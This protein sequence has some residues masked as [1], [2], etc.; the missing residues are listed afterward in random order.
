M[1]NG[2]AMVAAPSSPPGRKSGW[3]CSKLSWPTD[4]RGSPS[5]TSNED[6]T[7]RR[8]LRFSETGKGAFTRLKSTSETRGCI[9]PLQNGCSAVGPARMLRRTATGCSKEDKRLTE[10]STGY[11][12]LRKAFSTNGIESAD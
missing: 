12:E 11:S 4:V 6:D 8:E 10:T 9:K 2:T 7:I 3:N 5:G 1:R